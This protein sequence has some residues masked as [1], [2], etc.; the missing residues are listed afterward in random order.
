M[1]SR[2]FWIIIAVI[3]LL[4]VAGILYFRIF[5]WSEKNNSD[6]YL[7]PPMRWMK[8]D[9]YLACDANHSCP[10]NLKCIKFY[11]LNQPVCATQERIDNY[12][13]NGTSPIIAESYPPQLFCQ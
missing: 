7:E 6:F 4:I 9:Y 12:C 10:N 2:T 1:R 8:E 5:Y 3:V 13:L 11:N